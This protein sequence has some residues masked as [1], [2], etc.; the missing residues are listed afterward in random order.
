MAL[1]LRARLKKPA[2]VDLVDAPLP[3]VKGFVDERYLKSE[4]CFTPAGLPIRFYAHFRGNFGDIVVV[5]V[6]TVLLRL[7]THVNCHAEM[8]LPTEEV[9]QISVNNW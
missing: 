8:L 9:L 7:G 6:E 3:P 2:D 5:T 1:R 4:E